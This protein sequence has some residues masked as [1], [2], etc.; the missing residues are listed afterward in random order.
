MLD[1]RRVERLV[2]LWLDE[3]IAHYDLTSRSEEH[4]V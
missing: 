2:E 1:L 4:T 3:D